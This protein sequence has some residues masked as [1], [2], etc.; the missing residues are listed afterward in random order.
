M[1]IK[2]LREYHTW[3]GQTRLRVLEHEE[4]SKSEVAKVLRASFGRRCRVWTGEGEVT[5]GFDMQ[6]GREVV[7]RG[8]TFTAALKELYEW[9][10]EFSEKREP[11]G[12]GDG[13]VNSLLAAGVWDG[14]GDSGKRAALDD[15]A[16]RIEAERSGTGGVGSG[17]EAESGAN[18]EQDRR[19]VGQVHMEESTGD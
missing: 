19:V 11:T 9:L 6:P 5:I 13:V 10:A 2:S 14:L 4:P 15:V 1:T 12:A 16:K 7:A 17:A 8:T 3:N 18:P